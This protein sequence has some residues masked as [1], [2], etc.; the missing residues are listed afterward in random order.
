MLYVVQL[1]M[2]NNII[3]NMD[4]FKMIHV[5][6]IKIKTVIISCDFFIF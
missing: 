3:G 6:D 2:F 4:Y 5:L 1:K